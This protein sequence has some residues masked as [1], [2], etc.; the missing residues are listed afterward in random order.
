M[1]LYIHQNAISL[2][3]GGGPLGGG[4]LGGELIPNYQ[5]E[6]INNLPTRLYVACSEI[7]INALYVSIQICDIK[8]SQ[9]VRYTVTSS[10]R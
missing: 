2:P 9:K 1:A 7:L 5:S 6:R 8:T 10:S 3:P 4:P